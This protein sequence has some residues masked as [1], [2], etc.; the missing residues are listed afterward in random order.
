MDA[1]IQPSSA[2]N[3]NGI[4]KQGGGVMSG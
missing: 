4:S 1:K 2:Q 3:N